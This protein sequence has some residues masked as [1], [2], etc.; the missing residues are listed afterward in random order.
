MTIKPFGRRNPD[1][2]F[3]IGYMDLIDFE[4]EL[5]C[6]SDGNTVYPTIEDLK[7]ARPCVEQCGIVEVEVRFR[8]IVQPKNWSAFEGDS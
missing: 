3:V 6:A 1:D 7:Q 4:C 2:D 5:G 8:R